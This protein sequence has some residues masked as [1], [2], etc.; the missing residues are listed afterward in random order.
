MEFVYV[1]TPSLV[2]VASVLSD[3]SQA[4]SIS[5]SVYSGVDVVGFVD[6]LELD[7]VPDELV[8]PWL[9]LP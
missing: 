3:S 5:S 6:A 9:V 8:E 7:D 1:I 2:Q 4:A